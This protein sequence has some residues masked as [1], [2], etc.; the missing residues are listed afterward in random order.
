MHQAETSGTASEADS[1]FTNCYG[2]A[3]A[4]LFVGCLFEFK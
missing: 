2:I 4:R 1:E 3:G